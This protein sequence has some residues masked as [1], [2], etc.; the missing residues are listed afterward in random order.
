MLGGSQ[1][2]GPADDSP[3]DSDPSDGDGDD[4]DDP[5]DDD[6]G[7]DE[8]GSSDDDTN[9]GGSDDSQ[10]CPKKNEMYTSLVSACVDMKLLTKPM[11]GNRC[12][13]GGLLDIVSF[14]LFFPFCFL[15]RFNLSSSC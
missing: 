3:N 4:S 9:N 2:P 5:D 12:G 15:T 1:K 6:D 7:D 14:F 11:A 13:S 10:D 8:N